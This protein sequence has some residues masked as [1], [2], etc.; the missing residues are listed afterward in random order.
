MGEQTQELWPGPRIEQAESALFERF[1]SRL[2]E[3][4]YDECRQIAGLMEQLG[5]I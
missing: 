4:K 1:L 2:N 3:G 5:L